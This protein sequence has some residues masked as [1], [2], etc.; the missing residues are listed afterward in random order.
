MGDTAYA[1]IQINC[2]T[3]QKPILIPVP[4]TPVGEPVMAASGPT[5][6]PAP[7]VRPA[8]APA[9]T[10]PSPQKQPGGWSRLAIASLLCSVFLPLGFIPGL[11][12][13]HMARARMRRN[14]F[15][16]GDKIANAGLAVSYVMLVAT[17]VAGGI[18]LGEYL[19]FR[20]VKVLRNSPDAIAAMQPRI[21]DEIVIGENEDDHDVD[22]QMHYVSRNNGKS[23]RMADRGGSFSYQ[24]KV[25]PDRSMTLN[26][27]YWGSERK[28]HVFDIAVDNQIIATQDL[29][30]I[31]PSRFVDVEYRIPASLT[32]GKTEVKVEFQ[33]HAGALAGG[34]YACEMLR[35]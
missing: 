19:Y 31:A 1:G 5:P 27:R 12:C 34:L 14:I 16:E 8:P 11:I 10:A 33:A 7:G 29:T 13:G 17:M 20:P 15:L 22:G 6:P 28:N 35:R 9:S 2:P 24:M 32:H 21:V 30:G 26:C 18:F 23:S 4:Q 25:L 3:C